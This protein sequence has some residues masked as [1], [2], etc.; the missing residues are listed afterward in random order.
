L[1]Q[2]YDLALVRKRM[3][4]I[5]PGMRRTDVLMIL[6][7]PRQITQDKWEYWP[8]VIEAFKEFDT[9]EV[10]F[11]DGRVLKVRTGSA[12]LGIGGG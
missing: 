3:R 12:S 9:V 7:R 2:E 11:D 10:L 4:E 8:Q 1:D 5:K 6:G